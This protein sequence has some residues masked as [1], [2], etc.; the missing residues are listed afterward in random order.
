M[1][2]RIWHKSYA[3]GIPTSIEY[4]RIPLNKALERTAKRFPDSV[5]LIMMGEKISYRKLDSMVN[6]FARALANLGINKGDKVALLLPNIPQVVIASYAVFKLGAVVVMNN[7]LYTERELEYQLNDSESKLAIGLDLLVPRLL[8][9]K[10]KTGIENIISCHIRDFLPFPKKQLFP[11]VKKKMHRKTSPGEG[12]LEFMELIK[13]YP[14]DPVETDVSFEDLAALLYTGGTTGVSKGVLLTHANCCCCVQ[15][16]KAWLPDVE[17]GKDV[18]LGT[19]PIFHVA[20]FT[21][22]M[23]T[24]VYRGLALVMIP[25]PEPGVVLE[26]T[27]KFRPQW[28]PGVPTIFVG[29]LNHPDFSKTDFSC[30]KGCMS[31]AAP[32]AVETM[33]QWKTQVGA[34]IVECYGLTETSTMSHVNPWGGKTK[35]GSVGVP[36]P[37]TDCKIVDVET[38]TK[39]MPIGEP[40][41]IIIKGPQVSSGYYNKP[42]ETAETFRDGWLYT[43]DIGYMDE[44]G[45]FYIVD[46]KKDMI[47]AG[48]YNIYPRE[49]D[50]VLFEHPKIREAC[51][52]GIPDPYRGETV[53]AFVV[54]NEGETL[55]AE[56]LTSYC[57]ERLA[58]YKVPKLVEFMDELPKSAIGKVLR[59]ELRNMEINRQKQSLDP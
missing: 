38:G 52:V 34:D 48:G 55:T 10:E 31:G 11:L 29:V 16:L 17:E 41:E 42:K 12:V 19:F 7:P 46:R 8:K 36:F 44:E 57:R 9:L 40:G 27:R 33:R 54:L 20:G 21:T 56:E 59:R 14:S 39:E 58:P 23:N 51:A 37:D 18:M 50:E 1:E 32:L 2:Q 5:A 43:G 13:K 4:E 53:K 30:V 6:R 26:M 3:E 47:I 35:P 49:I 22:G 28:F 15:Q 24:A 25:R 45:Y